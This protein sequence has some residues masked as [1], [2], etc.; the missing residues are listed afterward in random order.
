MT[1]SEIRYRKIHDVAFFGLRLAVG[2]IFII[3]GSFKLDASVIPYLQQMGLPVELQYLY[4]FEEIIPGILLIA[5]VLSRISGVVL[6]LVMLGV[7]FYINKLSQF[8]GPN[9]IETPVML[10]A[11]SLVLIA[12]GPGKISASHAIR[13]IPRFLH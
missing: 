11:S 13:R 8:V 10:L 1:D 5:G 12:T 6:S 3:A 7:I 4:A 9:G 2:S